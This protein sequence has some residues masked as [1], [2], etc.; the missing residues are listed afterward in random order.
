MSGVRRR[1]IIWIRR[2]FVRR[3]VRI[4]CPRWR[5]Q[6]AP[7]WTH[8]PQFLESATQRRATGQAQG[9]C[10]A[11]PWPQ[12]TWQHST[13]QGAGAPR[14]PALQPVQEGAGEPAQGSHPRP[15]HTGQAA[16]GR[17]RGRG[18]RTGDT[19]PR[20]NTSRPTRPAPAWSARIT[21][22]ST[23]TWTRGPGRGSW[24]VTPGQDTPRVLHTPDTKHIKLT[25]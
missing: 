2:I 24:R 25:T 21:G 12:S 11:T 10:R 7:S 23:P 5:W 9:G 3:T 20:Q 16:Q 6:R 22:C 1:K 18:P 15:R 4:V 8:R 17:A 19:C 13:D 14:G